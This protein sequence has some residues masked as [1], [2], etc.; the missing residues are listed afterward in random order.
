MQILNTSKGSVVALV[1]GLL[2]L[3]TFGLPSAA[4]AEGNDKSADLKPDPKA[5]EKVREVGRVAGEVVAATVGAAVGTRFGTG[6][7]DAT[8]EKL[9]KVAGDLGAKAAE[10]AYKTSI[11]MYNNH[12]CGNGPG[13]C[14]IN[15]GK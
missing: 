10:A 8:T 9:T 7:G 12:P 1:F 4:W 14:P 15:G 13:S 5:T 6:A 11:E 2:V 3:V